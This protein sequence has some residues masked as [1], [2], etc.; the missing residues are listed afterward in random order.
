MDDIRAFLLPIRLGW[1][2][3][4]GG[5]QYCETWRLE[6]EELGESPTRRTG[7]ILKVSM[8]EVY[9]F[10]NL[11]IEVHEDFEDGKLPH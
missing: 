8:N 4:D 1:R 5:L 9:G 6:D 3:L 7:K 2:W 11:T 10:L